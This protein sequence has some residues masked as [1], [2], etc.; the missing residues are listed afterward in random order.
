M[1]MKTNGVTRI[2]ILIGDYAIK[3]PNFTYCHQHFLNGGYANWLERCYTKRFKCIDEYYSKIS[4]TIFC[5]WFGLIAIQKRVKELNRHL[6][7]EEVKYFKN[8]TA[9][10]KEQ[11]FGY[12]N[13][14]LVCIDYT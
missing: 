4:P 9:D 1:R 14:K 13:G 2:V 8:Q 12:L 6:T 10:I 7:K 3:I 5:S 11:N